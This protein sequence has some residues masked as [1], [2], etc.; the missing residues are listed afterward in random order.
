[1]AITGPI[2]SSRNIDILLGY[3]TTRTQSLRPWYINTNVMFLDIIHR[4]VLYLK[5]N[6]SE[7]GFRLHLQ[8]EPTQ[9]GPID[10]ASASLR[11]P[12]P[13]Q[14]SVYKPSTA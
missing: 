6:V 8:V 5:H 13:T 7:T 4:S 1:M 3:L 11:T 10:R 9:F 12:A 14:D 2:S